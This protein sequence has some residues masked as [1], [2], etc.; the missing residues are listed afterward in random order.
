MWNINIFNLTHKMGS[1]NMAHVHVRIRTNIRF[2]FSSVLTNG[3]G[4]RF[5]FI[6]RVNQIKREKMSCWYVSR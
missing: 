2:G 5:F 1:F 3:L 6:E 4:T